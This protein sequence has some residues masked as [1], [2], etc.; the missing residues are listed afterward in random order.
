[1]SGAVGA[2]LDPS[3][4]QQDGEEGYANKED[5]ELREDEQNQPPL[6]GPAVEDVDK[7]NEESSQA[8]KMWDNDQCAGVHNKDN[9]LDAGAP[10]K[11]AKEQQPQ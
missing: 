7:S 10:H 4:P 1:M 6:S 11:A 9:L 3:Q 5:K 8:D 2:A